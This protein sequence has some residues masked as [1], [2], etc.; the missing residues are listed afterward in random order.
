[1]SAEQI[2][3]TWDDSADGGADLMLT[4]PDEYAA[5]YERHVHHG[6]MPAPAHFYGLAGDGTLV[7]LAYEVTVGDWSDDHWAQVEHA[8]KL[9]DGAWYGRGLKLRDGLA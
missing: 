8:W 1:M 6:D 3:A 7:R 9:P 5:W 2:I 4:M